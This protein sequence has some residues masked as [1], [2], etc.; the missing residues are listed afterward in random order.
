MKYVPCCTGYKDPVSGNHRSR[1]ADL[2]FEGREATDEATGHGEEASF[3]ESAIL[4]GWLS[5]V[6]SL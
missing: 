5:G 3:G 2:G 1:I 4:R 6:S